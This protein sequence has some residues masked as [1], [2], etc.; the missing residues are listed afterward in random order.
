M[1]LRR[2]YNLVFYHIVQVQLQQDENLDL[3]D[4]IAGTCWWDKPSKGWHRVD[5][6]GSAKR[7]KRV[8]GY[9]AIVRDDEGTV[10]AAAYQP[11][12]MR[13]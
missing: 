3:E 7:W 13:E 12:V 6:D 2:I 9:G 11:Y 8:G 5:T 10:I 4:R 1:F